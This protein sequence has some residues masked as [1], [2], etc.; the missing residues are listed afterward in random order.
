MK[1]ILILVIC[2]LLISAV[3]AMPTIKD[4]T[5]CSEND[6]GNNIYKKGYVDL[7][8]Y[9]GNSETHT[10]SCTD[11]KHVKEFSCDNK[12][13]STPIIKE[14]KYGCLDGACVDS[15]ARLVSRLSA[16]DKDVPSKYGKTG[17]AA[18]IKP[19]L[20]ESDYKRNPSRKTVNESNK[21]T[22]T[23]ACEET[24]ALNPGKKGTIKFYYP[25]TRHAAEFTDFC[26]DREFVS[27]YSCL[28][29]IPERPSKARCIFL[30]KNGECVTSL[31]G[32]VG[33]EFRSIA[34]R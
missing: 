34:G 16:Y 26:V 24:D 4:A 27:E 12:Y 32:I 25:G 1:K 14:C 23:K 22:S 5:S 9:R 6:N 17:V 8:Y 21:E 30:C 18:V 7:S 29:T 2:L 20:R 10:D 31:K 33:K 11:F 19:V 3:G 13:P 15:P 28:N